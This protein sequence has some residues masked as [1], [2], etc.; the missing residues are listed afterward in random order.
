MHQGMQREGMQK[1]RQRRYVTRG[2]PPKHTL[3]VTHPLQTLTCK[4]S[5]GRNCPASNCPAQTFF[6]GLGRTFWGQGWLSV[7][8]A[9]RCISCTCV[10]TLSSCRRKSMALFLRR[11]SCLDLQVFL[12]LDLAKG[13]KKCPG[14]RGRRW[15]CGS[16]PCHV[17]KQPL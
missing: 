13:A 2:Y 16:V 3:R 17:W 9:K 6:L 15:F 12:G 10:S 7:R 5:N 8:R 14:Q 4:Q 11:N 1:D